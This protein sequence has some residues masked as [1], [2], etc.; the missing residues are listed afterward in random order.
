M[1]QFF[2]G[3]KVDPADLHCLGL[4]LRMDLLALTK[5]LRVRA[6]FAVLAFYLSWLS[7]LSY[8]CKLVNLC[9]W[10]LTRGTKYNH[11]THRILIFYAHPTIV[12]LKGNCCTVTCNLACT[13]PLMHP[14]THQK[15]GQSHLLYRSKSPTEISEREQARLS[16]PSLTAQRAQGCRVAVSQPAI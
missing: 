11:C 7:Q 13:D 2:C 15:L 4:S 5:I 12:I 8:L 3:C 10:T 1:I 6:L 9:V 14:D 16:Q